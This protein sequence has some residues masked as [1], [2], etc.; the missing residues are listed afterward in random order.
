MCLRHPE[1]DDSSTQPKTMH[2]PA[3]VASAAT[4]TSC[5]ATISKRQRYKLWELPIKLHC[6]IIGTCLT[7]AELRQLASK[8]KEPYAARQ[9]DYY[10]H[11]FFVN[12]GQHKS[13]LS[14]ATQKLL[15]RKFASAQRQ[16][17]QVKN[18]DE[19]KQLWQQSLDNG[20]VA[21]GLWATLTHGFCDNELQEEAYETI[22]MLSHQVGAGLQADLKK[23]TQTQ[24]QLAQL[25]LQHQQLNQTH[26]SQIQ[27]KNEQIQ[28]LK[29]ELAALQQA[30][31]Q[32]S[33]V[34]DQQYFQLEQINQHLQQ[35][36]TQLQQRFDAS[37]QALQ[38]AQ[39]QRDHWQL[40]AQGQIR[41]NNKLQAQVQAQQPL[42]NQESALSAHHVE[43]EQYDPDNCAN[44]P[45]LAGQQIL[46]VGGLHRLVEQYR[47]IIERNNGQFSHHDG[48]KE[49]SRKRLD[50]MLAAADTVICAVDCVSHDAYY[51]LKR[52][53]K[54]HGKKHIFMPSSSLSC[55]HSTVDQ[56]A[57][58][59]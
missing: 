17:S 59:A 51:R 3:K 54:Q 34:N 18:S 15:E 31:S 20:Q 40:T 13:P 41:E 9:N 52:Y 6:P 49:D 33:N 24:A 38:R 45:D 2:W 36:N 53:C 27:Y 47:T 5:A 12:H 35:Q 44:C 55:F 42:P 28:Q 50:S 32:P 30:Q 43:C 4:D 56:L 37:Q 39:A 46:C 58:K 25:T 7:S 29:S 23:L 57:T 1:Q 16:F 22:H 26:N 14:L 11:S 21:A 8:L 10:L 48:G 19:L